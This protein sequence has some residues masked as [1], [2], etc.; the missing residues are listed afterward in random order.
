MVVRLIV[1]DDSYV[2]P[3]GLRQVLDGALDIEVVAESPDKSSLVEEILARR[4]VHDRRP[5]VETIEAVA[6]SR[7]Q[8]E[9]HGASFGRSA[10]AK[11]GAHACGTPGDTIGAP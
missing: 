8:L 6:E 4:P 11:W 9:L 3:E 5:L 10:G 2:V 1:A 7:T